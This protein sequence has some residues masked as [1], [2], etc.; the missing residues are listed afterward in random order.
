MVVRRRKPLRYILALV[1]AVLVIG[2][3]V[4]YVRLTLR[5]LEAQTRQALR[6]QR[7][8]GTLPPE[9]QGVDVETVEVRDFA[10]QVPSGLE[11]R[12]ELAHL[13]TA[14]WYVWVVVVVTGSLAVAAL[15]GRWASRA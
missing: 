4:L 13:L 6:Q 3:G 2:L 8:D 14:F 9:L 15:V 12:L 5:A 11:I 10:M 1:I 7:K